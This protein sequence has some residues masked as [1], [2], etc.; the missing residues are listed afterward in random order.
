MSVALTDRSVSYS[1]AINED[2]INKE[3]RK[4]RRRGARRNISIK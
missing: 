2:L 3:R 4:V 1:A